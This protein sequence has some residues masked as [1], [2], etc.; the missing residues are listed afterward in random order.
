MIEVC[1]RPP[2]QNDDGAGARHCSSEEIQHL[3]I[4]Y[5][6]KSLQQG[7]EGSDDDF[8]MQNLEE[9]IRKSFHYIR[10]MKGR[11]DSECGHR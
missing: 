3:D 9:S 4:S 7:L 5:C 11:N 10:S 2:G 8:L 1:C 6:L